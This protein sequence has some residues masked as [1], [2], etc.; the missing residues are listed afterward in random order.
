MTV[1]LYMDHHVPASI[2]IELRRRGVDVIAAYEDDTHDW[3]DTDL[4]DRAGALARVLF[5]RD[6]DFLVEAAHRQRNGIFFYGVIYAHQL[7]ASIGGCVQDLEL[8]AKTC[9]AKDV[10]NDV[11]YLPV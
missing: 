10:I 1:A 5:T 11:I 7:R 4:L 2:T 9:D 6:E 3:E 8:I